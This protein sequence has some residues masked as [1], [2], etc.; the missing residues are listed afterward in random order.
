MPEPAIA[1]TLSDQDR[2]AVGAAWQALFRAYLRTREDV[3]GGIRLDFEPA[4]AAELGRLVDIE[5]H[6][7]AW[8]SFVV[9]GASVTMTAPGPGQE[10]VRAMWGSEAAEAAK[11]SSRSRTHSLPP[12]ASAA[13]SPTTALRPGPGP[14]K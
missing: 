1:C 14:R 2:A 13:S 12:R 7:C 10:A 4:G 5:R 8:A 6:C 3:P 11:H 9:E